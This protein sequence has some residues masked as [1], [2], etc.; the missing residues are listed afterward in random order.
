MSMSSGTTLISPTAT[1]SAHHAHVHQTIRRN[2]SHLSAHAVQ[3]QAHHTKRKPPSHANHAVPGPS[4]RLSDGESGR[5][6]VTSG[7]AMHALDQPKSKRKDSSE[8]SHVS[9]VLDTADEYLTAQR[10]LPEATRSDTH[11]PRLSRTTS[12]TSNT[13]EKKRTSIDKRPEK[14]RKRSGESVQILSEGGA[15]VDSAGSG[16]EGWESG[17]GDVTPAKGKE[18]AQEDGLRRTVSMPPSETAKAGETADPEGGNDVASSPGALPAELNHPHPQIRKTTGFSGSVHAADPQL[19]MQTHLNGATPH[20]N[21]PMHI[22]PAHQLKHQQSARSLASRGLNEEEHSVSVTGEARWNGPPAPM[23]LR[24]TQGSGLPNAHSVST[25]SFPLPTTESQRSDTTPP[26]SSIDSTIPH[27]RLPSESR[28][29]KPRI[30]LCSGAESSRLRHKT[31][32]SSLRSAHSLRAPPHPLNSPTGY[33]SGMIPIVG[34]SLPGSPVPSPSKRDRGPSMHHP[35]KAP[36]VVYREVATG[37]A[38]DAQDVQET[39]PVH[40]LTAPDLGRRKASTLSAHSLQG[41][42]TGLPIPRPRTPPKTSAFAPA[43]APQSSRRQTALEVAAVMSKRP[44]TTDA[45]LY[46]QSLGFPSSSAET[47]HLISRFLPQKKIKRPTW[48]ISANSMR[49]GHSGI[50]LTNGD[51]REAHESL[52]R[53]M[54]D[55]TLGNSGRRTSSRTH[56]YSSLLGSSSASEAGLGEGIGMLKGK[57]GPMVVA[58]GGWR[59]KTPFELSVER[60]LAQR[61]KRAVPEI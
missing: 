15:E 34:T 3:Q 61:P 11:L 37:L 30:R 43:M 13:S 23:R 18:K 58:R 29:S 59:G 24:S 60:C 47:A 20:W 6:A 39:S 2:S 22:M 28:P 36:P 51:Y 40:E 16:E 19:V 31:S 4:R 12:H 1:T 5:R 7:L 26:I 52:I 44:T 53:S 9:S 50:G 10:V 21:D 38:S 25:Q 56:S 27:A 33:R 35:P 54:R 48:E 49:E 41:I 42:L 46:H 17:E 32:N 8:V 57:N 55:M 14:D 45:A